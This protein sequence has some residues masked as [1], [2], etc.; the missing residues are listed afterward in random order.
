MSFCP[1]TSQQMNLFDPI[2]QLT[3]RERK[4][5]KNSWAEKFSHEI[6]PLI[7]EERFSVIY[8]DN[9]ATRPNNPVNVYIGLLML[10]EIFTQSD[11]E[12]LDSLMFD[13]RYQYALHTTSFE[14]QPVS[15]NSLSNFRTA[16]YRYNEKHGV[17]LIQEEVES[18]AKEFTKLLNI[19]GRTIRMDSLMI[20]SS[21]KKLS[22]LEI[23]YSCVSRLI[24]EIQKTEAALL[25]EKFKPYLKEGHRNDTIYRCKDKD[26]QTKLN[27]VTADAVELYY[28]CRDTAIED[29]EDFQILSRM[30]GEQTRQDNGRLELKP[31]KEISP[32]S[33]QNPTDTDATYRRKG[34]NDYVGFVANVVESFDDKNSIITHYDLKQNTY[35]D[36]AFSSDIIEKLG[37]QEENTRVLVDGAYYS[38]DI[39]KKATE[40]NMQ[41][42]PTNLVGR[43]ASSE[44][45]G[46]EA[47]NIDE[48]NHTVKNCPMGHAPTDSK[49]KREVYRAHFPREL[50]DNCPHRP[51]CPV[52]EQKKQYLLEVSETKFHR[53]VLKAEMG[54]A[55]YQ[56]IAS[57]RAGVEGIPSTL[58]RRYNVDHLPVRG[59][60]RSKVWLGFKIGAINCKR[61]I[62]S[63]IQATKDTLSAGIIKHL[64]E[65]LCFQRSVAAIWAA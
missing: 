42:I 4:H 2:Y 44:K 31:S 53:S 5:L 49:Y 16:V 17:D 33:L 19:D 57:K 1:N 64:L 56:E 12:C 39:S 23:I 9:P 10:K 60:V 11:E 50:C 7:N 63:R 41:F 35:S 27:T 28:L 61:Y 46:Y 29:S 32:Q 51:N 55:Q 3:E 15:K 43:Q 65:V 14:E 6:F 20:S 21:C 45:S 34:N 26:I 37:K 13:I 54:T 8:S 30:L 18:H 25:P 58:R 36:Q 24:E 59:K 62:K 22:R 40:N 52:S 38:E 48:I 47:F